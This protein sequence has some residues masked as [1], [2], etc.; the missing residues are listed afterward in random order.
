M[1]LQLTPSIPMST[2][3]GDGLALFIIDYGPEHHL[4]WTIAINETGEI[5]TYPNPEVRAQK[6]VSMGR[7]T[8]DSTLIPGY[9]SFEEYNKHFPNSLTGL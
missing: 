3:K 1:I 8:H 5:W 6:N 7:L 9:M 2:P 4:L